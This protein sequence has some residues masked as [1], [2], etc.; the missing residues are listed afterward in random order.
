MLAPY[1]P[2]QRM[3]LPPYY[4]LFKVI[5]D[6]KDFL[7]R[8]NVLRYNQNFG[9]TPSTGVFNSYKSIDDFINKIIDSEIE[10]ASDKV[11]ITEIIDTFSELHPS[12]IN[13]LMSIC[14]KLNAIPSNT[15]IGT[16]RHTI[17]DLLDEL[18]FAVNDF[19]KL[20][21]TVFK[22]D[23]IE[24]IKQSI[25][26]IKRIPDSFSLDHRIVFIEDLKE[27]IFYLVDN[28]I[29]FSDDN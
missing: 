17:K 3:W 10:T 12:P 15:D 14:D 6:G 2:L 8:V 5:I 1:R 16:L 18:S 25:T 4:L 19:W 13:S 9:N 7:G 27:R 28:L 24:Y 23:T 20:H 26:E 29:R 21:P 11:T 22:N